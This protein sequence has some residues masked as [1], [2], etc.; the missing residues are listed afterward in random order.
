MDFEKE[1]AG[2]IE[3]ARQEGIDASGIWE[4]FENT[5]PQRRVRIFE[6]T[7]ETGVLIDEYAFE[8]LSAIRRDC[9]PDTPEGRIAYT[10]FLDQLREQAPKL[11]QQSSHYYHRDLITFTIIEGRWDDLSD[12]LTDYT[13]GDHL[14]LFTMVVAQ[15]K[16][17]G[18][19]RILVEAMKAAYPK[20]EASSQY[21]PWASEEFAGKLMEVMLVDYLERTADPRPDDPEFLEATA[22]LPSWREGWLEWF[23]PTVTRPEPAEWE[24][25][26][27]AD[28]SG[29]EDWQHKFATM[30]VECIATQWR[31]GVPLTRGLLAWRKWGEIFHDQHKTAEKFQK[32]QKRKQKAVDSSLSRYMIPQAKQMDETLGESFSLTGGEPYEVA[33]ALELMPA[34][35][36][37]LTDFGLIRPDEKQQALQQIKPLVA[38]IPPILRYYECD[39][40]AIENLL[41]AWDI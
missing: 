38:Q 8:F 27:F 20:I 9:D 25:S 19:V 34:Y 31:A 32:R 14:D 6:R 40:V 37:F 30:Q 36:D 7:L 22:Y 21:V 4:L 24:L 16:Y 41:A 28:D 10:G 12:L 3:Y 2:E 26:D 39:P 23:V 1:L 29:S 13:S 35:L 15:L 17:H 18:Q 33:A 11:Y 5:T